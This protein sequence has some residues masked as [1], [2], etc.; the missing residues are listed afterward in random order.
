MRYTRYDLKKGNGFNAFIVSLLIIFFLSFIIGTFVFRVI[1]RNT[2][3]FAQGNVEIS[4]SGSKYIKFVVVQGG[5]Y[6]DKNN[7]DI[8]Q[9]LL[10]NYGVPFSIKDSDKIKVYVGIY[11]EED[12]KK[13]MD[14]LTQK[15]VDNTKVVFT[16]NQNDLYSAEI[17]EII[18]ANIKILNK[19]SESDVNSIK[20]DELKKWC[21]SLEDVKGNDNDKELILKKLKE[22]V[23]ELPSEIKK[24][25]GEK[26]YIYIFDVLKKISSS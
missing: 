6:K 15:N 21:I 1:I 13:I 25:D 24:T 12:A 26:N 17:S 3:N 14:N 5:V 9:K 22:Y 4:N 10:S 18:K 7:A 2:A 11:T 19:L 23:N 20:T 8:Q 16:I